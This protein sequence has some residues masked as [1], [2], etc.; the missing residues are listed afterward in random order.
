MPKVENL[1]VTTIKI[2]N[3][4]ITDWFFPSSNQIIVTNTS[5]N[6]TFIWCS[7]FTAAVLERSSDNAVVARLGPGDTMMI[8]DD[9]PAATETYSWQ[10]GAGT[11]IA[12]KVR[13][14]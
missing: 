13:K 1:A 12:A 8:F 7:A 11:L 6:P 10:S 14:K 9:T 3:G 2:L 4:A 5:N